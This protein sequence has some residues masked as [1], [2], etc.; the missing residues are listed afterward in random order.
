MIAFNLALWLI[1]KESF[2][3]LRM[4]NVKMVMKEILLK[5]CRFIND[6][7]LKPY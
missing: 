4:A 5:M 6:T 1:Y 2:I 7:T 3:F